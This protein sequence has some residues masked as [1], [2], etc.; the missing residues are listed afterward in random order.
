MN[1]NGL[2]RM[3]PVFIHQCST[4][5]IKIKFESIGSAPRPSQPRPSSRFE[6][7]RV[8][9][10][11]TTR[12]KDC[13]IVRL[14]SDEYCHGQR[15][16]RKEGR[17]EGRTEGRTDGRKISYPNLT[18]S[19]KCSWISDKG[20]ELWRTRWSVPRNI[21]ADISQM[22]LQRSH[23]TGNSRTR[24]KRP[25]DLAETKESGK[26]PRGRVLP[27]GSSSSISSYHESS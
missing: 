7:F 17:K 15:E 18:E 22:F 8:S 25:G 27:A 26:E 6:Q 11:R 4:G 9:R 23:D 1:H 5:Q 13:E 2:H 21:L 12:V 14:S 16:G 20:R 19:Y 10:S 3:S 24:S